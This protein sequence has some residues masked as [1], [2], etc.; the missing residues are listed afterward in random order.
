LALHDEKAEL[1]ASQRMEHRVWAKV[2][3][4]LDHEGTVDSAAG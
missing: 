1:V 4:V 3:G 2:I